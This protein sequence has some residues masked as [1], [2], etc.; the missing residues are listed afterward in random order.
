MPVLLGVP[1]EI[2][3]WYAAFNVFIG[4]ITHSNVD[5]ECGIF[6]HFLST[7]NLHRWHHSPF[8]PETDT[9]FGETTM[10]W[11]RLFGTY[12]NPTR[13]PRRNVGL[14]T[15]V[16]VSRHFLQAVFQPFTPAGHRALDHELIAQ[17]PPG[18]AGPGRL[19]VRDSRLAQHGLQTPGGTDLGTR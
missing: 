15:S 7:P 2:S 13:P 12:F 16:R 4:L 1:A 9:N 18:D 11:D 3:L 19:V 8:Q 17:L 14:G 10:V 5:V 6:N